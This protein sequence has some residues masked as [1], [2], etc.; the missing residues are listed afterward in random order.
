MMKEVFMIYKELPYVANPVS[1]IVF[2]C[3]VEPM[4]QGKD[5][6]ETLDMA[7]DAGINTFD[8]AANYGLSEVSLGNWLT[9]RKLHDK[10]VIIS[11]CCHPEQKYNNGAD[12]VTPEAIEQDFLQSVERLGTEHID[13]YFLH[14]DD[15]KVDVGPIIEALNKLHSQGKI[16][17]FGGSNWTVSRIRQAN[18]YAKNHNLVPFTVSS[19]NFGLADQI[20]DPWEMGG[21]CVT[22]SGPNNEADRD[23]YSKNKMPVF[24]Y[25]SLG[26]GLFTGRIKSFQ[27]ELAAEFLDP[28]AVK[29]YCCHENFERLARVEIL[30]DKLG[31]SVPQIAIAWMLHQ[32]ME[33]FSLVSSMNEVNIRKNID[34]LDIKLSQKECD[35]LDLKT[36]VI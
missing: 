1:R 30:A 7:Y 9:S 3:A 19:P 10:T 16:G 26:H 4:L 32:P 25:S 14:R 28:A 34:A 17:A 8:T 24:A 2:G 5:I 6:F 22:I 35:W 12:R 11:K 15:L 27:E 31:Y 36:K 21:G 13:I 20:G 23:W 29:G 18:D 33:V